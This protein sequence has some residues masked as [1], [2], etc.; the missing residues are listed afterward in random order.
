MKVPI[1]S[2]TVVDLDAP[3][4][5]AYEIKFD[6]IARWVVWFKHYNEWPRHGPAEGHRLKDIVKHTDVTRS[7]RIGGLGIIWLL[8]ESSN[9]ERPRKMC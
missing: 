6:G 9:N 4:L 3:T 2:V 7:V 5:P 1:D 8:R